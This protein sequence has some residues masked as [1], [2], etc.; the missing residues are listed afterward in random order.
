MKKG[1]F[2]GVLHCFSSGAELAERAIDIGFYI[3]F[4][5]ILTFNKA[6]ELRA[7]AANL[8]EDRILVETDSPYLTPVPHRGRPNEP[9]YTAHTLEKLAT[10]RGKQLMEMAHI[11]RKNTLRL[12]NR[13]DNIMKVTML[14]CGTSVGVPALG[15]AGWGKCNPEDERNRRQRCAVLVEVNDRVILVDAGPDIR[16]QLIP[17]ELK[18]IDALLITHTHSDHVAGLDDLRAFTGPIAMTYLFMQRNNIP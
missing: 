15:Q 6:E 3:S 10:V 5:G 12:F 17:L 4:S 11:T 16:N 1:D 2:R 9:A 13:M 18:K 14:G 7:I 8:P